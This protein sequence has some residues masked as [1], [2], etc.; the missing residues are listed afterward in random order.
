MAKAVS[1][2]HWLTTREVLWNIL[3]QECKEIEKLIDDRRS[4]KTVSYL[5]STLSCRLSDVQDAHMRYVVGVDKDELDQEEAIEFMTNAERLVRE[6]FRKIDGYLEEFYSEESQKPSDSESFRSLLTIDET[7]DSQLDLRRVD[8]ESVHSETSMAP[9]RRND[10]LNMRTQDQQL[11]RTIRPETPRFPEERNIIV[12]VLPQHDLKPF[13]GDPK[14]WPNFISCF[15]ELVHNV[16]NSDAQRF[17]RLKQLLSTQVRAHIAEYLDSPETYQDALEAL[18]K[19]YGQ[20]LILGRAHLLAILNVKP[21]KEGDYQGLENLSSTLLSAIN[22][23]RL[24][25]YHNDLKS[26]FSLE[27]VT[28]KIPLRLREK[29][30]TK[31]LKMLPKRATLEDFAKWLDERVT[32]HKM[33]TQLTVVEDV[34]V[35]AVTSKKKNEPKSRSVLVT[36]EVKNN[37]ACCDRPHLT[38]KCFKF[39]DFSPQQKS[40]LIR[41]KGLCIRCLGA[42]H[43][44]AEC[45]ETVTCTIEGCNRRHH[46]LLHDL[47][48]LYPTSAAK[49]VREASENVNQTSNNEEKEKKNPP[50][51]TE[52]KS[53]NAT[54]LKSA[55]RTLFNIVPIVIRHKGKMARTHA[56]LDS[57]SDVSL[58]RSDVAA[59]LKLKGP[60]AKVVFGSFHGEEKIET[61]VVN[62]HVTS[63]N[64][65]YSC[66]LNGVHTVPNLNIPKEMVDNE[67]IRKQWKHLK[68]VY[69]PENDFGDVTVLI[70]ASHQQAHVQLE[71]RHPSSEDIAPSA[72]RTPFGW[73]FVGPLPSKDSTARVCA[74][75]SSIDANLLDERLEKFWSTESFPVIDVSKT[76]P[77]RPED[78]KYAENLVKDSITYDGGHYVVGLPWKSPEVILPDNYNMALRRL[79]SIAHRF[80]R[81]SS[82]KKKY[83]AIIDEYVAKGYARLLTAEELKGPT[84]RTWYLPHHGVINPQKPEKLRVVFDASAKFIGVS[85]NTMLLKGPNLVSDLVSVLL[86]FREKAVGV[87]GDIRQMFLQVHVK[88]EDQSVLRFLWYPT[89]NSKVPQVYQMKVQIFGAV[90]SPFICTYVLHQHAEKN[91][92]R[93]PIVSERVKD[94]FYVDNLFDSFFKE[95]EAI[96]AVHEYRQLLKEAGFHLNQ[97]VSSSRAV[98]NSIPS[99][100]WSQPN[101]DLSVDEMPTERTLGVLFNSDADVFTFKIRA[102]PD[103]SIRHTK[104]QVLSRMATIFD[105]LGFVAPV[106]LRAKLLLQ[107][108]WRIE[109]DWDDEVTAEINSAWNEWMHDSL[110]LEHVK[111]HRP[112]IH[113]PEYDS[114]ELHAFADA[115]TIGFGAVVYLRTLYNDGSI[116]CKFVIAKSRVAP[117]RQ[118][119]V[120]RLELQGAVVAVRLVKAV[121]ES[122]KSEINGVHFW[123]DSTTVLQWI[124]SKTCRFHAFVANRISEILDSSQK[125]QWHHVI[126]DENPA[127][128]LSRGLRASDL[129]ENHRWWKGPKFLQNANLIYPEPVHVSEHSESDCEVAPLKWLGHVSKKSEDGMTKLMERSSNLFRVRRIFAYVLRFIENIRKRQRKEVLLK[130]ELSIN[131]LQAASKACIKITQ[132]WAFGDEIQMLRTNKNLPISSSLAIL[133]PFLDADGILRV[134]GRI[135]R[136]SFSYGIKHPVLLPAKQDFT[137]LV[138]FDAHLKLFHPSTERLLSFLREEYWIPKGRRSIKEAT[139]S[140]FICKRFFARPEIPKMAALPPER[141]EVFLP[142]FTN[143]GIDYFGPYSVN[144]FRKSVKRYVL[145]FT[146]LV[147]RAVHLEVTDSFNTD[148]FLMA[149]QRF[150]NRR[151][152][153][154][155]VFSDNG[156][157]I[158]AGQNEIK[159]GLKNLNKEKIEGSMLKNDIQWTFSPPLA[160]HFGGVWERIVKSAKRALDVILYSRSV[161]DEMFKTIIVDVESLLNGR[162]LTHI[163]VDPKDPSPLTPNH[164]LLG[165]A[166]YNT[167]SDVFDSDDLTSRRKWRAA[168]ML[169]NQF[170]NRWLKEYLPN[171]REQRKWLNQKKNLEENDI[172]IV[173]E[174]NLPR[175][176]WLYGR[177][178]RVVTSEDGAV[179]SAYVLTK[180][181]EYHRPVSKLCFLE[182][183]IEEKTGPAVEK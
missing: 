51:E 130:D 72:I 179:R 122:L 138:I 41:Q 50:A 145:L 53:C 77:L 20:P 6:A 61:H 96:F 40:D 108:I 58:I 180:S 161:D 95:E 35:K 86:R 78:E 98:M 113:S 159:E 46:A 168:Q 176:S 167:P 131:E 102:P 87:S 13:C 1:S 31:M 165:R 128:E 143:T 2:E 115:S 103:L 11:D 76:E 104:R 142:P 59:S 152:R 154:K 116:S 37:C 69:P 125:H 44:A 83:A 33:T 120:P 110:C 17:A 34:N 65:S 111:I 49:P 156:T 166:S 148:S 70:G 93:F 134:G 160:P 146:C 3:K 173:I 12:N 22:S 48:K 26:S 175:G 39:R 7:R 140:C 144:M 132:S 92:L 155:R 57:A 123:T 74:T 4:K 136:S 171:L 151:G 45:G 81:D 8:E 121:R 177:V 54:S 84:G 68:D 172:V 90:S 91:R 174:P 14:E 158:T 157:Q 119:T 88:S 182:R 43:R 56:I 5:R 52:K 163:S 28:M 66:K 181:G 38:T 55:S 23:L 109:C 141:T 71:S 105:P 170:W 15:T 63:I 60:K 118:L 153:P 89:E 32:C 164:F 79:N 82:F 75:F 100:D 10:L 126:S 73:S 67:M 106:V 42:G 16:L 112:L 149:F 25:G 21:I 183:E 114:I 27:Q 101:L 169:V 18:N 19:R 97:W 30:G 29:W 99:E 162:P 150:E 178:T 139:K 133:T 80:K 94:H 64:E 9:S 62:L 36:T 127:D 135:G 137:R 124:N 85:L 129:H 117:V 47:P 147:T 24:N 107:A